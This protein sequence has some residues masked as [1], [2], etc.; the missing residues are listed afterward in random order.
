MYLYCFRS[1]D[2]LSRSRNRRT[3]EE[4]EYL[5]LSAAGRPRISRRS[6]SE[7]EET[8][9]VTSPSVSAMGGGPPTEEPPPAYEELFPEQQPRRSGLPELPTSGL[10]VRL[11][12]RVGSEEW[13]T[14]DEE[15]QERGPTT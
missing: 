13:V 15:D 3:A 2:A 7:Y 6:T 9:A 1:I 4:N 8:A 11:E 5:P 10:N 14:E 12:S